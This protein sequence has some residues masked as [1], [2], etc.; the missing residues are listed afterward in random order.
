[1]ARRKSDRPPDSVLPADLA[2]CADME[3]KFDSVSVIYRIKDDSAFVF[4]MLL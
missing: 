2:L 4:V 1:M 3:L